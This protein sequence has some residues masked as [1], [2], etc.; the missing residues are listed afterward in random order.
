MSR[1]RE[2]YFKSSH[3]YPGLERWIDPPPGVTCKECGGDMFLHPAG[4]L[5]ECTECPHKGKQTKYGIA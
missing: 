4:I 2:K 5:W 3:Y 1:E